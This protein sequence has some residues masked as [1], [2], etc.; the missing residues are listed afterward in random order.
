MFLK[1]CNADIFIQHSYSLLSIHCL[2]CFDKYRT[3][4][5]YFLLSFVF[6]HF[7]IFVLVEKS[8]Q[9]CFSLLFYLYFFPVFLSSWKMVFSSKLLLIVICL[10]LIYRKLPYHDHCSCCCGCCPCRCDWD[11]SLQKENK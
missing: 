5:T 3:S 11:P 10:L 8:L 7:F 1:C 2:L 6:K 9:A 4:L